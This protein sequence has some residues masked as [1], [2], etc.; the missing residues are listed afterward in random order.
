MAP[1]RKRGGPGKGLIVLMVVAVAAGAVG[2]YLYSRG[3]LPI[4]VHFSIRFDDAK[5]LLRTAIR[6]DNP[7]LFFEHKGIYFAPGAVP[8]GDYAIP[9]GSAEVKRRGADVT[10]VAIG[11]MVGK[12]LGVAEKLAEEGISA[13]VIDPRTLAPLDSRTI[14]ESVEKTG[15]LV[16]VEEGCLTGGLG[17]EVAFAVVKDGTV[18]FADAFTYVGPGEYVHNPDGIHL[19]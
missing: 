16:T 4:G 11:A 6:S 17:A 13:E 14:I 12:V 2:Y 9:F 1:P 7:V 8:K 19:L 3:K 18:H 10:V 5:G 15:R